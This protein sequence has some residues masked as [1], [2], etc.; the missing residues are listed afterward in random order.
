MLQVA[1]VEHHLVTQ[2]ADQIGDPLLG[3]GRVVVDNA[4]GLLEE[5]LHLR[6]RTPGSV[7][8]TLRLWH[9]T[10]STDCL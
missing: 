5:H 8:H 7:A 4:L 3:V 9:R 1:E 2:S 10:G 6:L